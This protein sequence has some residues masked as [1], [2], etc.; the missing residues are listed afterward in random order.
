MIIKL[1]KG[2][3]TNYKEVRE[4]HNLVNCGGKMN[5]Y[6]NLFDNAAAE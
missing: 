2:W 4:F 6:K 3:A 1:I 5:F